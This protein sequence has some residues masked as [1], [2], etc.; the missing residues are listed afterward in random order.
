MIQ[1]HTSDYDWNWED[2]LSIGLKAINSILSSNITK[3]Y[4]PPYIDHTLI[5]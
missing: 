5:S 2:K 3:L 4:D 1:K